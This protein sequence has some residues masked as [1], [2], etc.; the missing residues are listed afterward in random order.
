MTLFLVELI[1]LTI[2]ESRVYLLSA[3]TFSGYRIRIS[4]T[5]AASSA[6]IYFSFHL[7]A[8]GVV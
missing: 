6:C 1:I 3:M 8:A 7:Q 4:L 5:L 2:L